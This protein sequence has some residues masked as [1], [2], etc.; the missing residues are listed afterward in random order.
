MPLNQRVLTKHEEDLMEEFKMEL[1]RMDT[2]PRS[3]NRWRL[4]DIK[5]EI[6]KSENSKLIKKL[7]REKAN[8]MFKSRKRKR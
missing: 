6:S 5:I 2:D 7:A 4:E 3:V 1:Y 8:A